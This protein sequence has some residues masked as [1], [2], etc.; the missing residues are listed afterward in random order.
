MLAVLLVFSLVVIVSFMTVTGWPE[1]QPKLRFEVSLY[2]SLL[3]LFAV[4][5]SGLTM[6]LDPWS[7]QS[8]SVNLLVGA[9]LLGMALPSYL[10][11][12]GVRNK[13]DGLPD[14]IPTTAL[15]KSA[16]NSLAVA[17]GAI[18][19]LALI[20][21][22]NGLPEESLYII[23]VLVLV[24]VLATHNISTIYYLRRH[25]LREDRQDSV[26]LTTESG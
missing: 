7:L 5:G 21:L 17:L 11:Y 18:A 10:A 8:S 26:P 6:Y 1:S 15:R 16:V 3:G 20:T 22:Y 9:V 23:C 2:L 4:L 13:V 12:R 25:T 14:G 24:L 19:S